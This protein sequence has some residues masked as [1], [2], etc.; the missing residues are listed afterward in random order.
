MAILFVSNGIL[1]FNELWRKSIYGFRHRVD[2]SL[3]KVVNIVS[4]SENT[5]DLYY[6]FYRWHSPDAHCVI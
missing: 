4:N 3:N 6:M 2:N 5:G 1:S